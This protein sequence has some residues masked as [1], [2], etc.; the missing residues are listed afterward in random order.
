MTDIAEQELRP[1][2]QA[3]PGLRSNIGRLVRM[4]GEMSACRNVEIDVPD[5][6][7]KRKGLIRGIEEYFDGPV[8]GLFTYSDMCQN[9]WLLIATADGIAVRQPLD[10]PIFEVADCYPFDDFGGEPAEGDPPNVDNWKFASSHLETRSQSLGLKSSAAAV[11]V[12]DLAALDYSL[13]WFKEACGSSYQVQVDAALPVPV[14][15]LVPRIWI[16]MRAAERGF[17]SGAAIIGEVSREAGGVF[18]RILFLDVARNLSE[19][20]K[21]GPRVDGN[22][23]FNLS[24]DATERVVSVS[25]TPD[26]ESK[27]E[28]S[29]SVGALDDASMGLATGLAV[30]FTGTPG[31][32]RPAAFVA[33]A[34][35]VDLVDS[36]SI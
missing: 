21:I 24:Y 18:A 29:A 15:D 20:A 9:E 23:L 25:L 8:C 31:I 16:V 26:T 5:T 4:P 1:T 28:G 6:L 22:V 27:I 3:W 34:F 17:Q 7:A 2:A 11:P 19:L 35:S 30:F 32:P 36:G 13:S 12:D 14:A 33:P 10:I